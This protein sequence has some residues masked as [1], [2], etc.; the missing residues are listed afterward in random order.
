MCEITY[1][2]VEVQSTQQLRIGE[3]KT[4]R[5]DR[6]SCGKDAGCLEI[7]VLP[8]TSVGKLP[9]IAD[10]KPR[11]LVQQLRFCFLVF[12]FGPNRCGLDNVCPHID[13]L[14][15]IVGVIQKCC[16]PQR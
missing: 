16:L 11:T 8:D 1:D 12:E 9:T 6:E 3:T 10:T 4:S 15:C 7:C 5:E 14:D 2:L 13:G